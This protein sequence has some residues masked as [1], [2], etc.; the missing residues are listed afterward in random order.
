MCGG[1]IDAVSDTGLAD[2]SALQTDQNLVAA[3][4]GIVALGGSKVG[5]SARGR[6]SC[7]ADQRKDDGGLWRFLQSDLR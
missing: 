6:T 7:V 3:I 2:T 5:G 4:V 1:D